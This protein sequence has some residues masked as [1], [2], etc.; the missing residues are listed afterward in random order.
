MEDGE[1][2]W[3]F[4]ASDPGLVFPATSPNPEVTQEPTESDLIVPK[5]LLSPRKA[6]GMEELFVRNW[7]EGLTLEQK[8]LPAPLSLTK[9]WRALVW[10][11]GQRP[12]SVYI[13]IIIAKYSTNLNSFIAFKI[14][15]IEVKWETVSQ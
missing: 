14:P 5:M 4:Q 15:A 11:Q 8:M 13:F 2:R 7:G 12:Q 1:W 10:S 3:K 6:Q 9:I